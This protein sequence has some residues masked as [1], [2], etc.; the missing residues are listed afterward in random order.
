[1]P[2]R[3]LSVRLKAAETAL[4]DGR[5]DEAHRLASSPDLRAH[6]RGAAVLSALAKR[7]I[8]RARAHFRAD[9]YA[10]ALVDLD[11]A[12]SG[13][14][15]QVEISELR[16]NVEAVAA[17]SRRRENVRR[18]RVETARRRI[19]GGSLAAGRQILE[20]ASSA[21]HDA[22]HLRGEV[23]R[24]ADEARRIAE[25]AEQ[26]LHQGQIAKAAKRLCRARAIDAH[27]DAVVR[28]ESAIC[29]RAVNEA[30]CALVAGNIRRAAQELE[31]LGDLGADL[32]A[33]GEVSEM[34]R[35]ARRAARAMRA[36]DDANARSQA[37]ALGRLLPEAK[38]IADALEQLRRMDEVRTALSAGPL[39]VASL[40][41]EDADAVTAREPVA[42]VHP[43]P[44]RPNRSPH[45]RRDS[46]EAATIALPNPG[47]AGSL[48]TR[49][50]LLVDGGGSY[51]LLRG[52]RASIGRVAAD[53]PADVPVYSD[54]A[55]RHAHIER[56]DDDYFLF[57]AKSVEV[58]GRKVMDHLLRD[59][60]R[61]VLGRKA[62]LT[63]RAPTRRSATAVIDLSDTTKMPH[64]VRRVVL[65]DRH[66][67]LGDGAHAHIRC[68]HAGPPLVVFER[69]GEL[70]VRQR[71]DGHVDTQEQP[72]RFGQPVE[73]GGAGLVIQ[74]WR[75]QAPGLTRI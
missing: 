40:E 34:V 74:P 18:D 38:W 11:R 27:D 67:T 57:A 14:V 72:L 37:T 43:A 3:L 6:R 28:L 15:L 68:R 69:D 75:L 16:Q 59:G 54:I 1:M 60:D 33:L 58:G 23:E 45:V 32:P 53:D 29:H 4:R 21:D 30:R 65:F 7:F 17:E 64:D 24:R 22:H 70:W 20:E 13:G 62:K 51:L 39:G 35:I 66:A 73:I 61:V 44:A 42:N 19:Q 9:R 48:P 8:E 36:G 41:P 49:M 55:Q 47:V 25:Q 26:L 5:L 46:S 2:S 10:D 63:F 71:S 31:S 52:A 50:L 12:Q 56:V